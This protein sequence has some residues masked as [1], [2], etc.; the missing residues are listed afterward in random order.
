MSIWNQ[1]F[2]V[3][4][5][6]S[7]CQ[8]QLDASISRSC[9]DKLQNRT[10]VRHCVVQGCGNCDLTTLSHRFPK[11][12]ARADKWRKILGVEISLDEIWA[13]HSVC[14]K[15]FKETDYR[16][17]DSSHLNITAIPS[18]NPGERSRLRRTGPAQLNPPSAS[19]GVHKEIF[20]VLEEGDEKLAFHTSSKAPM[21]LESTTDRL[22]TSP[23]NVPEETVPLS[24]N[25]E[26]STED[27][28]RSF[29]DYNSDEDTDIPEATSRE[30]EVD[31]PVNIPGP[32][33]VEKSI[34]RDIPRFSFVS[35]LRNH[36]SQLSKEQLVD[37]IAKLYELLPVLE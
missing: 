5:I 29:I 6:R 22:S 32:S 27:E 34:L 10:M 3:V 2:E 9:L 23:N 19:N 1:N 15:H 28:D 31:L 33:Q 24:L 35:D 8:N 13:K 26:I 7:N 37:T 17:K 20:I 18:L 11:S 25:K 4:K 30:G 12:A 14:C 36:Y 16:R 21:L